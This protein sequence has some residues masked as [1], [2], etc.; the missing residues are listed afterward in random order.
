MHL[1]LFEW[2]YA[3]LQVL[4][5]CYLKLRLELSQVPT[6]LAMLTGVILDSPTIRCSTLTLFS[7]HL[8]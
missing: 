2:K 4:L 8:I 1:M 7:S 3:A 6:F 5:I